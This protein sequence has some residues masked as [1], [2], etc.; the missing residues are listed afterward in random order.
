[1]TRNFLLQLKEHSIYSSTFGSWT[2]V[3]CLH[4]LLGRR[5]L[6]ILVVLLF[7][8]HVSHERFVW[9]FGVSFEQIGEEVCGGFTPID[10]QY[11]EGLDM[12]IEFSNVAADG[13]H[14]F[15]KGYAE[16]SDK[17][18]VAYMARK[19]EDYKDGKDTTHE[20]TMQT[21]DNRFKNQKLKNKWNVPS[22]EEEKILALQTKVKAKKHATKDGKKR[23]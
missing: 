1:M 12:E 5:V 7:T 2:V 19:Q 14:I 3:I 21:A 23:K 9:A 6:S 22:V 8:G 4:C 16:C 15:V 18:F 13:H 17:T 10:E 11:H 20:Q